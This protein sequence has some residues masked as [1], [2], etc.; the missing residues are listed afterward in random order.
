MVS[1]VTLVVSTGPMLISNHTDACASVLSIRKNKHT[2]PD[3]RHGHLFNI[4]YTSESEKSRRVVLMLTAAFVY[5]PGSLASG[6]RRK[7]SEAF[8]SL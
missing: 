5:T 1:T 4:N 6:R 7:R 3:V 8:S 2:Q